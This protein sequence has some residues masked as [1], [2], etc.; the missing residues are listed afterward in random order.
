[1]AIIYRINRGGYKKYREKLR[2]KKIK[3]IKMKDS[4]Q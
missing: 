1:M 2:H 4:H 3:N